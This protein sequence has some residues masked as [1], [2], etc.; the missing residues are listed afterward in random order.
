MREIKFRAWD[1][2]KKIMVYGVE[3]F[4]DTLGEFHDANGREIDLYRETSFCRYR[5]F[6]DFIDEKIPL[7]QFTGLKDKNRKEVY[8]NDILK[9]EGE[10]DS[11]IVK[12][13]EIGF[14]CPNE[15][16]RTVGFI[17]NNGN[18]GFEIV[19]N[20]FENPDLMLDKKNVL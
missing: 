16:D 12:W 8:E 9:V 6:G 3:H 11:Q 20:I 2:N 5:S 13:L 1:E 17:I 18:M 14:D 15:W 4:Y 7:M 10:K 19:G